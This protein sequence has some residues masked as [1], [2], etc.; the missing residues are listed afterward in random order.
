MAGKFEL[1]K[2]RNAKFRFTLKASNGQVILTSQMY[3][4]KTSA[5][6]G[7]ESVRKNS[8]V[9]AR[10]ERRAS[11]KDEPF[12]VL[13]AVNAQVVGT[14]QMYNTKRAME[15]GIISVGKNAPDAKMVDLS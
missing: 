12:F 10:F 7:I 2:T 3:V 15:N 11:R 5:M 6:N 1:K 13:K 9:E 4:A 8:Q 14:S